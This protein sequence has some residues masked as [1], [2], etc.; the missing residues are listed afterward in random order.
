MEHNSAKVAKELGFNYKYVLDEFYRAHKDVEKKAKKICEEFHDKAIHDL[1]VLVKDYD[2]NAIKEEAVSKRQV[3]NEKAKIR[4]HKFY[5]QF[6]LNSMPKKVVV[7]DSPTSSEPLT[8]SERERLTREIQDRF[9]E[10]VEK[11]EKIMNYSDQLAEFERLV[12]NLEK[13]NMILASENTKLKRDAEIFVK[14]KYVLEAEVAELKR[15]LDREREE[16]SMI[17]RQHESVVKALTDKI[18]S[19]GDKEVISKLN[20]ENIMLKKALASPYFTQLKKF[21]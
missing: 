13:Q 9:D 16:K 12:F 19:S 21:N 20:N 14:E 7:V 15:K 6:S 17:V 18:S 8:V 11:N 1:K 4:K 10:L 2:I 5:E 3:E